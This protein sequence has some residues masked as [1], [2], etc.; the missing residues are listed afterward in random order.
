MEMLIVIAIIAVLVTILVPSIGSSLRKAR[1]ASD[2]A[3][4]RAAY[5]TY[6]MA[7]IEDSVRPT[8]TISDDGLIT[9]TAVSGYFQAR[10]NFHD[11]GNGAT[12][13]S[14]VNGVYSITYIP[15]QI[16]DGT[17]YLWELSQ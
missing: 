1:E 12:P 7:A 3:N 5:A 6:Q 4:I 16:N 9:V 2:V 10:L 13:M 11:L 15:R 14:T 17:P 8:L